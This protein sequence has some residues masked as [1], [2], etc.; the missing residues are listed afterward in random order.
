[1]IDLLPLRSDELCRLRSHWV[2][3]RHEGRRL[4]LRN[5]L[6]ARWQQGPWLLLMEQGL[7]LLDLL[8]EGED[9][10]LKDEGV[11]LLLVI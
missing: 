5:K 2:L 11:H 1:M 6:S 8:L 3:S 7:L 4:H 10:L 9:L